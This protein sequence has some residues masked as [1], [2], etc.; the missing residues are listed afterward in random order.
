MQQCV[1][2]ALVTAAAATACCRLDACAL[3]CDREG[4]SWA[5]I[6]CDGREDLSTHAERSHLCS[7]LGVRRQL[8]GMCSRCSHDM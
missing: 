6:A 5:Q 4:L 8:Q 2:G 3:S 1:R 7:N